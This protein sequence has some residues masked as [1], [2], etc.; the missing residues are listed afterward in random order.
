MRSPALCTPSVRRIRILD[1]AFRSFNLL[2]PIAIAEPMSVRSPAMPT[3]ILFTNPSRSPLS[4][5]RGDC[6]KASSPKTTRPI[7]SVSLFLM[8]SLTT[9]FT[10]VSR[11]TGSPSNLKS[12]AC[13]EPEVSR[14]SIISTPGDRI[15]RDTLYSWGRAAAKTN[16]IRQTALKAMGTFARKR[17]LPPA[18]R[19]IWEVMEYVMLGGLLRKQKKSHPATTTSRTKSTG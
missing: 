9:F 16:R 4:T 19:A 5:V 18:N 13:I 11:D 2:P 3:S 1:F 8:N 17:P 14:Q 12:S 10:A 15:S 6:V 7:L